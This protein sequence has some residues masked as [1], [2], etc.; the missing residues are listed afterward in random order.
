LTFKVEIIAGWAIS[1]EER[2][3]E[4][5]LANFDFNEALAKITCPVIP[6]K[7]GIQNSLKSWIPG[8]ARNNRHGK[9]FVIHYPSRT[10]LIRIEFLL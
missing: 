6:A 4:V 10:G 7:A 5:R 9:R 8:H 3:N 1:Q 2:L